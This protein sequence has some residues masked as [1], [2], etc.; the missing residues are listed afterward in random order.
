MLFLSLT[1]D[2]ALTDAGEKSGF[3]KDDDIS[4]L[5]FK[6]RTRVCSSRKGKRST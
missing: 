1:A 2:G 6:G 5:G 4:E 3:Y